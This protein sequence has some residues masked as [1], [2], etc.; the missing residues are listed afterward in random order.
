VH[1][2]LATVVTGLDSPVA[3]AWRR[4]DAKMYVAQQGGTLVAVEN[5]RVVS[6]P[7]LSLSVSHGNEQGLLGIAFSDDG[8]KLFVDYTDPKGDTHV[9]EYTMR[10]SI[11][12]PATARELLFQQ[13]PFANHNGGDLVVHDGHLYISL[14]DGGSGGDPQANGQNLGR[15]LGKILRID[16]RATGKA[17]YSI[18]P[19]N[20]FVS[21]AGARGEVWMYGLRNPW[22]FSFDRVTGDAWIGDVGQNQYEEV[23]FAPAGEDGINWGWSAR[24]G[25]HAYEGGGSSSAPGARDPI[26]ETSHD[27]G[28][29]ALIGG[30]VYRGRAVPSLRGVYV[31]GDECRA[32]LVGLVERDGRAVQQRALGPNVQQLTSFGE[33]RDGELYAVSRG[34]TVY[35]FATGG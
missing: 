18:P 3:L 23:D 19:D 25:F 7:V 15:L 12:D 30:Y 5:G 20:P 21:R 10:G 11:A 34:G 8:S 9:V 17:P 6:T 28:N 27:D 31:F 33:D 26:T 24:E 13:Q 2:G 32:P 16:P 14:G 35:R 4:N 22:R 29:C 1:I